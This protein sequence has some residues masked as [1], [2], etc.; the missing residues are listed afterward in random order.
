[1]DRISGNLGIRVLF[2]TRWSSSSF[3]CQCA[4]LSPLKF[5][6]QVDKL[7]FCNITSTQEMA[8]KMS[9]LENMC[10]TLWGYIKDAVSKQRYHSNESK[11]VVTT[12]FRTIAPAMLRQLS[13]RTWHRIIQYY[14]V[15]MRDSTQMQDIGMCRDL[16]LT[17][18]TLVRI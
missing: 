13:Y 4:G 3:C 12:A 15:R 7:W 10:N 9:K 18:Y 5:S 14:A 16:W 1:M 2:S 17:L 8:C 6:W 11:A